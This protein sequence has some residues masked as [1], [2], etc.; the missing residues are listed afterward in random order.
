MPPISPDSPF[1][2]A[3]RVRPLFADK[4]RAFKSD[5]WERPHAPLREFFPGQAETL[6]H[7]VREATTWAVPRAD[8]D[9]RN[10][11]AA[12]L[13]D[14]LTQNHREFFEVLLADMQRL[15]EARS[16]ALQVLEVT[17][18]EVEAL[19]NDIG[20]FAG[21]LRARAEDD[22]RE[23]FPR[24]LR[25]EASLRDPRVDP[26]FNGGSLRKAVAYRT[27]AAG[28][29]LLL[30]TL[31][32]L[33]GRMG[34]AGAAREGCPWLSLLSDRLTELRD[35]LLAHEKLKSEVL[36]PM[37]LEAEKTL[38]NLSIGG[39]GRPAAVAA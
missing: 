35:R 37:A 11:P 20:R 4:L 9:W 23:L 13:L 3:L 31:Q 8:S 7:L 28:R 12:H 39:G 27:A 2:D 15:F 34:R 18:G 25:Y 26:E 38:Y 32:T 17:D 21:E 36:Y 24:V 29:D 16:E 33:L 14:H 6:E 10:L 1:Q 19:R 30:E 22:E 5:F